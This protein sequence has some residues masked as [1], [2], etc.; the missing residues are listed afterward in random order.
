MSGEYSDV[1]EDNE[2]EDEEIEATVG[3]ELVLYLIDAGRDMFLTTPENREKKNL[4]ENAGVYVLEDLSVL[5]AQLINNVRTIP[6]RFEAEIGS[7]SISAAISEGSRNNPLGVAQT[8]LKSGGKNVDK[9]VLLFTNNDDPF[10]EAGERARQDMHRTTVQK[11]LDAQDVGISFDLYPMSRP[12]GD[13]FTMSTFY[14]DMIQGQDEDERSQIVDNASNRLEELRNQLKKKSFRKRMVRR[15]LFSV[16]RA[17]EIALKSY[18]MI[19]PAKIAKDVSVEA[20]RNVPLKTEVSLICQDTG[21]LLTGPIKRMQLYNGTK[22]LFHPDEIGAV[23][24]VVAKDLQLL[25]FKPLACLQE[26][27]NLQPATF[28]YPDEEAVSGSTCAFI[29]LHAAMLDQKKFAVACWGKSVQPRLVALLAQEERRDE[30]QGAQLEPPGFQMIFQP[31]LDDIR[32]AELY[33]PWADGA[34]PRASPEQVERASRLMRKLILRDFSLLDVQNPALQQHYAALEMIALGYQQD[35]AAVE[36]NT[37]PDAH[38]FS[39]PAVEAVVRA[40][41]D[42]VYGPTHDEDEA[43]E[44]EKKGAPAAKRKALQE[45]AVAR[46]ADENWEQLADDGKLETLTIEQLK[47]YLRSKGLPVSGKKK[48]L[49]GRVLTALGR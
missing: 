29:A 41:K 40:F 21:A 32:A 23:K 37:L 24:R 18:A 46:A 35:V 14:A 11:A 28:L 9:R 36:D 38:A 1:D 33:H 3:K 13:R 20:S 19:R 7:S 45:A 15:V 16:A 26:Y 47:V 43:A 22:A 30:Q 39:T 8:M 31:F 10:A 17:S 6:E 5:S 2:N 12:G 4:Q 49:V 25:G 42:E 34:A 44:R 48:D 27:H